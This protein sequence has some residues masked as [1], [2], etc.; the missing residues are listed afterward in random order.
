MRRTGLRAWCVFALMATVP[1]LAA[2]AGAQTSGPGLRT[3]KGPHA[4]VE[5]IADR[6]APAPGM[7]LGLT[8]DLDPGWHIY[9]QNPGDSGEPPEATWAFPP[10]VM[11]AGIEWPAPE[12]IDVGGLVNY[13]YHNT[14]VLPVVVA[15]QA[16]APFP[17]DLTIKA[18]LRWLVCANLCVPGKAELALTFPLSAHEA[19]Q[20]GGWKS[21]I[22]AARNH[23][24]APAPASWTVEVRS[25]GDAFTVDVV[26]GSRE[27]RAVFFPLV[28]SEVNDSAAQ[29]VTPLEGGVRIVLQKS[30]QLSND[31]AVLRG[32][33]SLPGGR[34]YVVAAPVK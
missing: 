24:P 32:V 9:W 17:R 15:L 5:L 6:A 28:S 26:T 3:G 4:R 13:G 11:E 8:F 25:T 18:S 1:G 21:A 30:S 10:G 12:R 33:L 29:T 23:V 27:E 7:R 20:V 34:S 19:A 22:D 2:P 14:V 16:G 31:P